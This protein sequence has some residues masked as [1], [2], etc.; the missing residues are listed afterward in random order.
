MSQKYL[1][2]NH[3]EYNKTLKSKR[4]CLIRGKLVLNEQNQN[5]NKP[6]K[7]HRCY[8]DIYRKLLNAFPM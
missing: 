1:K 2:Y 4:D 8:F 5:Q 7:V 3:I 6:I